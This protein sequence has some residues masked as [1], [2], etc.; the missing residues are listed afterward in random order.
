MGYPSLRNRC[1][2][3]TP[4]KPVDPEYQDTHC[5]TFDHRDCPV[6]LEDNPDKLPPE[7]AAVKSK[8]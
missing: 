5:F 8:R 3:V 4:P 6:L 2:R 1:H 7:I